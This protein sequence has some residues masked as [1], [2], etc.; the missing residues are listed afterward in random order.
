M[1]NSPFPYRDI[2]ISLLGSTAITVLSYFFFFQ[3][4]MTT[5]RAAMSLVIAVT[6][7]FLLLSILA[8]E[9]TTPS[10][11]LGLVFALL[12]FLVFVSF[13]NILNFVD[14]PVNI[15]LSLGFATVFLVAIFPE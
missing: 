9:W 15:I 13:A 14:W 5:Q 3:S 6:G 2:A 11:F 1:R 10:R 12:A 4:D 7:F 8:P